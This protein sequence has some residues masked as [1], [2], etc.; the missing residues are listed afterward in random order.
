M[1]E[2][3]HG[4]R[5][6]VTFIV[7]LAALAVFASACSDVSSATP[8]ATP[9]SAVAQVSEAGQVTVA[10]SWAGPA[11]GA[12]FGVALDTHSVDLDSIDLTR[13][14]VLRA[15]VMLRRPVGPHRRRDIIVRVS[16]SFHKNCPTG[17]KRSAR[18]R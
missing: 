16:W 12:R 3:G 10:I 1:R 2:Q 18:G 7:I 5:Q 6:P 15:Q 11:A 4:N 14:A 9:I 17:S 8:A 13:Q